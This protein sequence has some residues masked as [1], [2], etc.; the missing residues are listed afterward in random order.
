M[1]DDDIP[2]AAAFAAAA[3]LRWLCGCSLGGCPTV[4]VILPSNAPRLTAQAG[5]GIHEIAAQC[6]DADIIRYIMM[7]S[8]STNSHVEG[9]IFKE[10]MQ[11]MPGLQDAGTIAAEY[12]W[13]DP[14][15]AGVKAA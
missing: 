8:S 15:K 9:D 7:K 6:G 11:D 14:K 12:G 2:R 1:N 10:T 3:A 13:Q 4:M 5:W